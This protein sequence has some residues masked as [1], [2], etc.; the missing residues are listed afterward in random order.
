MAI[1]TTKN[2]SIKKIRDDLINNPFISIIIPAININNWQN[3]INNLYCDKIK[4]E[5]IFLG[6]FR[7]NIKLPKYCR[8]IQTFVKP[9]QCLEIGYRLSKGNFI[10]QFADDCKLSTNNGIFKIY[11]LW[12][13]NG[14][15]IKKLISCKYKTPKHRTLKDDYRFM[16][17]DKTSPLLPITPL[18]PKV[19]LK[20]F[21]SYDKGFEAVL[22]DLDLYM[23][24][25]RNGCKFIFTNIYYIED[26]NINKGNILLG[27]F[28]NKDKI[29]LDNLWIDDVNKPLKQRKFSKTRNLKFNKFVSKDLIKKTQEPYGKWRYNNYI[30]NR[31]IHN[32]FFY[33]FK[34]FYYKKYFYQ[35][36]ISI[37]KN[38][39][40]I[41][42][43]LKKLF[44]K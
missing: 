42:S 3:V 5:I 28:W 39:F 7:P 41:Y 34:N 6:P 37:I 33:F 22:A 18:L 12:K 26:K 44:K 1:T 27:D 2:N 16:P 10:M 36:L 25:V 32:P 11:N 13:K 19:L 38:N 8:Y 20:K 15:D 29:F 23:R 40:F 30:Y 43:I 4:F 17:W 21:G 9:P 14:A 24:L 35:Y 31:I